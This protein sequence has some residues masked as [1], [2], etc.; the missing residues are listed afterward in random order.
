MEKNLQ[1]FKSL[2][3]KELVVYL[4]WFRKI[5]KERGNDNPLS[6]DSYNYNQ[7]LK[8]DSELV[9]MER[10]LG[11]SESEKKS[12]ENEAKRILGFPKDK[13]IG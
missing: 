12:M 9:G 1:F 11:L 2:Y 13:S 8:R 6:W 4:C 10:L 7:Y 3:Y 5:S